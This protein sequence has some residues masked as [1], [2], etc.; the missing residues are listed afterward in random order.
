MRISLAIVSVAALTFAGCTL[1]DVDAPPLAGPSTF[2]TQITLRAEPDQLPQ[3][4][5]AQS[6]IQIT[7]LGPDGQSRA[8]TMRAQIYVDGVPQDYGILDNKRPTTPATITYTAPPASTVGG[9]SQTIQIAVTPEGN[10]FGAEAT[11]FINLLLLPVGVILPT[12]PSLIAQFTVTPASPQAFSSVVFDAA[13]TTNGGVPCLNNCA[14]SWVFGDGNAGAGM[15][16][17]H[18]YRTPGTVVVTLTVTDSRG[19]QATSTRSITVTPSTPPTA[20]FTV[21]PS[22]PGTNQAIFF[23]ASGSRPAAGRTIVSY[24]WDF[25]KGTTGSGVTVTKSYETPGTYTVTL[26]VTDDAQAIATATQTLVV[27]SPSSNPTASLTSSPTAP[28]TATTVFFDA[29]GSRP[30][31]SPIVEYRFVWGDNSPDTVGTSTNAS[32]Q[33]TTPGT[34]VVRLIVTDSEG[35]TGTITVNVTVT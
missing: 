12:N 35:R 10:D 13:T 15:T 6:R 27:G 22:N 32:H 18:L 2:A 30:A 24:D 21:S 34:Y 29:S 20:T 4:G 28:T 8:V 11:R 14:Y 17:T 25:G 33:F 1:K 31:S 5:T 16:T 26:R 3:N 9:Q 19:A 23:N 7:A